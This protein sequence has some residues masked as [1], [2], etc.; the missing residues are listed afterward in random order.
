MSNRKTYLDYVYEII[1]LDTMDM[2]CVYKDYILREVGTYGFNA[3]YRAGL[4]EGCGS[5]NGRE[6]FVLLDKNRGA[7]N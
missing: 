7:D 3:L 2:D 5:L 6:L 1:R 4:L